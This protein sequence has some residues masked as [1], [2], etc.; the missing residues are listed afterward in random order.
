MQPPTKPAVVDGSTARFY[1]MVVLAQYVQEVKTTTLERMQAYMTIKFGLKRRTTTEMIK[2]M[3][4]AHL[5]N[6][7]SSAFILTPTGDKWLKNIAKQ[8]AL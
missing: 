3:Q 7:N 8:N 4:N 6:T 5:L 1:R 2:D